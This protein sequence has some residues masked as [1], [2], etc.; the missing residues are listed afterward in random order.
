MQ[1]LFPYCSSGRPI[2]NVYVYEGGDIG[3]RIDDKV[4][5]KQIGWISVIH[6]YHE[7]TKLP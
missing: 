1:T 7:T 2:S 4:T 6:N 3:I 5:D